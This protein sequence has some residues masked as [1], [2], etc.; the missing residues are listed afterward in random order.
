MPYFLERIANLLYD[1][2]GG[3]LRRHCLV[4]PSRR[5]GIYFLKYLA[6]RIEKPVWT[7]AIMTINDFFGALSELNVAEN[8]ILLCELYKTYRK[9]NKSAESFDDFYFWGDM[10]INDFDDVDKYMASVPVLFRNVLDF[11]NIDIQFG[12]IDKEQAE[13]IKRFWINFE[14]EKPSVEK[15]EFKAVWAILHELY[16]EFRNSLRSKNLAYEGMIFRDIA[17]RASSDENF[18]IKWDRVHFIGFNA[19]N[20]CEETVMVRLQKSERASFYWDYD[21]SYIKGGKLNSA[22]LF[23]SRNQK[24]FKNDMPADW[25]YNTRLSLPVGETVR[26]VIETT[27]DIAQVKLIRELIDR[28]PGLTP[29]NAH[30]TAVILADENLLVPVLTSLPENFADINISMG[31]PLKM[32]GVYTLVR[33]ILNLQRNIVINNNT[34]FFNYRDIIDI[35]RH[36]LIEIILTEDEKNIINEIVGK[37]LIRVPLDFLARSETLRL[38][39]RVDKDPARLSDHLREILMAVSGDR[40]NERSSIGLTGMERNLRNEFIYRVLLSINRLETVVRSSDISFKTETYIRILDKILRNQ[41]VPFSGE[42]L[43]GIQ[44]MGILE[45]RA[46]DFENIIMLSVNEGILPGNTSGSS[47]IPFTIREA[48]GLPTINHQESIFAY[49][50]YRLLHRADRVTLVYNSNS[51]GLRT[52]EMSR[53]IIQMKYE[54]ILKADIINLGFDIKTPVEIGPEIERTK[55][56]NAALFRLYVENG[57]KAVLSPTAINTWLNCRMKFYYRYV[58]GLKEPETISSEIDHALFGQI[59][60]TIMKNIY[61]NFQGSEISTDFLDSL[62]KDEEY[63]DSIIDK[64]FKEEFNSGVNWPMDGNELIMRDILQI[65]LIR[66][67]KADRSVSPFTIVG[68]EK[69]FIFNLSLESE[70]KTIT[71]RTGGTVDRIDCISGKTRIVDYK[72]GM[73]ARRISSIEDLFEDDRKGDLDG[74]LQ[75]LIYCE[76][77]LSGNP[78]AIVKPSVYKVKELSEGSLYDT[79]RIKVEKRDDYLIEDYN[80]EREDFMSLLKSL[81]GTIFSPDE[82]FRMTSEIRKC[83]YCPYRA[84]CQR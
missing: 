75:T 80:R 3:D 23:L 45:T 54:Q 77:F 28:I 35:L 16:H 64:S 44:I 43:S 36:Q 37:N 83:G 63:L 26:S 40:D 29:E 71:I 59:L 47:F 70:G 48:F 56:H 72:T 10:L 20:K 50:F 81:V 82:N 1:Q 60:H 18:M 41:S 19:L 52:G 58:N 39:F 9:L 55:K 4:F 12:D 53:F 67:L 31:Y 79:L 49:H 5:A 42:P 22:G 34:A 30:H 27:S 25:N 51:E 15:A 2:T 6:A 11:R 61:E 68:I 24:I 62:I 57:G 69:P 33:Y 66:V 76:A 7:P 14:P 78:E 8:E 84:L 17:E 73:V 32:T 74:W 46:L 21:N 13:I 38:I 65:Y